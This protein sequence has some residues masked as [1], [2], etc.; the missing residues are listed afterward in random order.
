MNPGLAW[1]HEEP[2]RRLE[3]LTS[4]LQIRFLSSTPSYRRP[5]RARIERF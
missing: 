2:M 1:V 3:L 4:G 5:L